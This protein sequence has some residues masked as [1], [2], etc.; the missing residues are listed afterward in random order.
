MSLILNLKINCSVLLFLICCPLLA[1]ADP[2]VNGEL[3]P[4]GEAL[5]VTDTKILKELN[6]VPDNEPVWCYSN[7]ANSLIISSAQREREKCDL[8]LKQEALKSKTNCDFLL[9]QL[10]ISLESLKEKQENLLLLKNK[11][12]DE[13]TSVASSVPNDYS[14]WWASGGVVLGVVSTLLIMSI[15][16]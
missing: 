10:N 14:V 8:K 1:Y 13:L 12:I 3:I 16:Q 9:E 7:L 15:S 6:L 5:Y 4:P 11:Q 2:E